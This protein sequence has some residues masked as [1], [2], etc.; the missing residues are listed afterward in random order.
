M[1]RKSVDT[2]HFDHFV[3][4]K[5]LFYIELVCLFFFLLF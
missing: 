4:D 3:L 2:D 1:K 5:F